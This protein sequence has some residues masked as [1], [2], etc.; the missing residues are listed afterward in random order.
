MEID[1]AIR[2]LD[3][4]TLAS[5]LLMILSIVGAVELGSSLLHRLR[6]RQAVA[7]G[8]A[9]SIGSF[10]ALDVPWSQLFRGEAIHQL[11]SFASSFGAP[12]L[13]PAFLAQAL[14]EGVETVSMAWLAT[15]SVAILAL[16]AAP[17]GVR[18]VARGW[19][20]A[21]P[22]V[23]G[24]RR[25]LRVVLLVIARVLFQ[26]S[27]TLPEIVW[28]LLFIVWVGPGVLAGVLAVA[29]HSFGI[30]ARL[31]A[32]V[33]AETDPT[34]AR[35]LEASGAAA[36]AQWLYGVLPAAL[37][38]MAAYGLF[39]FE[40]NVRTTTMVG[41]VGAGGLGDSLHTALSLF[42]FSDLAGLLI[43]LLAIVALVDAAGERVRTRLFD[44][45]PGRGRTRPLLRRSEAD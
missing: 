34:P 37:P 41:F 32:E 38:R 35:T 43:V 31:F 13:A 20:E 4:G 14:K 24:A 5:C 3:Y 33:A 40:V 2:Y 36:S 44:A 21:P 12:T 16:V 15:G 18:A 28:A 17:F 30:L 25:G 6:T 42:H 23:S 8:L 39:R 10:V 9:L 29:A 26:L 19:L 1:L 27:R 7:I 11:R 22:L 45:T